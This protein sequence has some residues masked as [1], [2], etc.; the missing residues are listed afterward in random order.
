[1]RWDP[2]IVEVTAFGGDRSSKIFMGGRIT[3]TLDLPNKSRTWKLRAGQCQNNPPGTTSFRCDVT[4][5]YH[6]AEL[7]VAA[8]KIGSL[9]V[10]VPPP[11]GV[12]KCWS[13]VAPAAPHLPPSG[14]GG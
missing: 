1:V 13:D 14:G 5:W 4:S 3:P 10:N 7:V 6:E 12:T 9:R 11:P 8:A 2:I